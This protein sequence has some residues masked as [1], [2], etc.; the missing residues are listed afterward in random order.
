MVPFCFREAK[1]MQPMSNTDAKSG[2]FSINE[3][4]EFADSIG[5]V[6]LMNI[7]YLNL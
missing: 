2:G 7:G 1:L 3:R 6:S 5:R 4:G